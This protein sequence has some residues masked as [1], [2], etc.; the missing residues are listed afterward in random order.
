MCF[1]KSWS[2]TVLKNCGEGNTHVCDF[3]HILCHLSLYAAKTISG[4]L[5][6]NNRLDYCK[7]AHPHKIKAKR[8]FLSSNIQKCLACMVLKAP[9]S[10]LHLLSCN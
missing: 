6:I 5:I 7:S 8:T 9:H 3:C 10:L 1:I 4:A 2:T